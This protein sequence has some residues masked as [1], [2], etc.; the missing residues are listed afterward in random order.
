MTRSNAVLPDIHSDEEYEKLN[1]NDQLFLNA[2]RE[3]L[4]RH[5]LPDEQLSLLGG[6]NIVFSYGDQRIVKIF[7][8]IH[9]GQFMSET[10]V[11]KHL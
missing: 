10:L 5:H 6:T 7:P 9:H 1:L 2:A 3:I 8:P 11:M 4:A